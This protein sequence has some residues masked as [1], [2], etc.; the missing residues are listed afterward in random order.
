M[1]ESIV[2]VSCMRAQEAKDAV[3]TLSVLVIDFGDGAVLANNMFP[4]VALRIIAEVQKLLNAMEQ[5]GLKDYREGTSSEM[6]RRPQKDG[7]SYSTAEDYD[8]ILI[9]RSEGTREESDAQ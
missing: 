1:R 7:C 6:F 8:R 2:G 5:K 4:Q 9:I 3:V